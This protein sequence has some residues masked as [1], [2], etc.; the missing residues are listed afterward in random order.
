MLDLLW[1]FLNFDELAGRT[2]TLLLDVE[3]ALGGGA[4]DAEDDDGEMTL[5]DVFNCDFCE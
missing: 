3:L 4:I 5:V 2:K 1:P